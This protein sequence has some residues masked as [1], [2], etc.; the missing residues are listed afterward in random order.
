M[1][2]PV[3]LEEGSKLT[4]QQRARLLEEEC[5]AREPRHLRKLDGGFPPYVAYYAE[6]FIVPAALGAYAIRPYGLSM[7]NGAPPS[8]LR[9]HRIVMPRSRS[10]SLAGE[11]FDMYPV[12]R[13]ASIPNFYNLY[14]LK[15]EIGMPG[16]PHDKVP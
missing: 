4:L 11:R 8:S 5:S 6:T 14:F 13:W 2:E 7:G 16:T 10:T 9:P 3:N 1:N 12:V 15:A